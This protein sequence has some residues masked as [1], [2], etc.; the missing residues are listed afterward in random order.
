MTFDLRRILPAAVLALG[1]AMLVVALV[2]TLTPRR[3]G[4]PIP[5]AVGGAFSLVA[6]DGKPVTDRDFLGSPALV[7]FG[8]THCPD[9]CPTTMMQLS[10]I[11]AALGKDKKIAALFVTVDPERDTPAVLRDYLGSFDP[12]IRGLSGDAAATAA[13]L[14]AYRVYA[15][16]TPLKDG[17]YSMDH[18]SLVYLIDKQGQFVSAFNLE[19]PVAEAAKELAGHLQGS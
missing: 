2:V 19:R 6:E 13:V 12:R 18:T 14:K 11:F 1:L 17:G 8:Y 7:F 4:A 16:K 15:R 5:P 3:P 10:Q 9:V